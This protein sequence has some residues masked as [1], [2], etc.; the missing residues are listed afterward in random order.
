M[1]A[2][3]PAPVI[4]PALHNRIMREV[5]QPTMAGMAKDGIPYT[6]FLYAG[7]MIGPGADSTRSLKVLEFN[8][9]LGDPETQPIMMRIKNDLTQVFEYAVQGRLD[10]SSEERR[11]GKEVVRTCRARG[12]TDS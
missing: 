8:C 3:S 12:V 2:Y 11:V 7:L 1:G 10:E 4:T 5:I 9:R 6:G